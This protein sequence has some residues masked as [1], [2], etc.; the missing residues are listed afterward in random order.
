MIS[1]ETL[2]A[3][4]QAA[5]QQPSIGDAL[6]QM[7]PMMLIIFG[8]FYF[9]YQKPMQKEQ[10]EHKKMTSAL[11]KGDNLVTI[12]GIIG[13]VEEVHETFIVLRTGDSSSKNSGKGTRITIEKSAIRAKITEDKES[14]DK[15]S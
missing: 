2:V 7:L 14:G 9:V 11:L 8:I 3:F 5:P 6:L 13:S 15:A 4:A 12:G 1:S 10:E